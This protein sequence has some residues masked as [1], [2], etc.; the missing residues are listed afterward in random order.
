MPRALVVAA[1][2]AAW[3]DALADAVVL[4]P[5]AD[6]AR[7]GGEAARADAAF[8]DG[9]LDDPLLLVQRLH[10]LDP[11]LQ[12]A[13]VADDTR[14]GAL[15]RAV[16]FARGLGELWIVSPEQVDAELME[17]AAAITA[18]RR[19]Y[20]G[21]RQ[22]M[23]RDLA[24]A[25]PRRAA[26]AQVSD[27]FLAAL[28]DVI[29]DPVVSLDAASAVLSWN[30]AAERV[31]GWT[32][33]EAQG[34]LLAELVQASPREEFHALLEDGRTATVRGEVSFIRRSG[35]TAVAEVAVSPASAAGHDV[36]AVVL[37]DVTQLRETQAELEAQA[38][39]LEAQAAEMEVINTELEERSEALED[40]QA[41]RSRF[42][43]AMS[44]ELRTP[45][46]AVIGYNQLILEGIYGPVNPAQE[47]PLQ[48]VRRAAGHLLE[49]VNDVL[50]LSKIEAGRIDL[51][52]EETDV[53]LLILELIDT[54]RPLAEE[55][56]SPVEARQLDPPCTTVVTDPRRLR[57]I[58]LNLL[59]N[60]LKFGEGKPVEVACRGVEE[61][62]VEVAV[63]DHGR[64]IDP[65]HQER[66][67]EE[68]V[69]VDGESGTGTGLG[70]PISR[71]LAQL[72]G[73]SLHVRSR[74]GEG[75]TFIVRLPARLPP[76]PP[77]RGTERRRR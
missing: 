33:A 21:T 76:A 66:I 24:R 11:D 47:P 72:L 64:G 6:D 38:A 52:P 34:R 50:D 30:P 51:E 37:H 8:V 59:S 56:G 60:A 19:R 58:L 27:A 45:I 7:L 54:V 55:H 75:S 2:G 67:F 71:R 15:E 26:R 14:R 31:L 35:E 74:P 5:G 73:G 23:E 36:R 3:A 39:E 17:R 65:R 57:Q 28:L 44:H 1:E 77:P 69:Q 62:G 40:A 4:A 13:V 61:G 63:T 49:L 46:N 16:L 48:R 42:Y 41:T 53:H 22:A 12:P 29:P 43:A 9:R 25:E 20:R 68:F 70:L 18:Q 32:R 10:A